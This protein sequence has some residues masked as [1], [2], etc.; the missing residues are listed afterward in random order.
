LAAVLITAL[1]VILSIL[2]IVSGSEM[3]ETLGKS[4]AVVGVSTLAILLAAMILKAGRTSTPDE[5]PA[6][7]GSR[8]HP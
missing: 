3:R 2:D 7:A 6:E 5:L 8:H 1:M 4:L